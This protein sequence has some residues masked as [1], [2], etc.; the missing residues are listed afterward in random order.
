MA[1]ASPL[2]SLPRDTGRLTASFAEPGGNLRSTSESFNSDATEARSSSSVSKTSNAFKIPVFSTEAGSEEERFR[3][4]GRGYWS[5]A[6]R[7]AE[8]WADVLLES[9]AEELNGED[10]SLNES[11]RVERERICSRVSSSSVVSGKFP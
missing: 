11:R 10:G 9:D 4:V 7:V 3:F 8:A 1:L 6:A 5:D 2:S